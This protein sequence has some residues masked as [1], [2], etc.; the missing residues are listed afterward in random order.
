VGV[1]DEF[2]KQLRREVDAYAAW[3]PVTNSF[4]LGDYGLVSNGVFQ[5]LGNIT[6][7]GVDPGKGEPSG[8]AKIDFKSQGTTTVSLVGDA[9]VDALPDAPIDASLRIEFNDSDSCFAKAAKGWV[10]EIPNVREIAQKL[11]RANGWR[12]KYRVV[13]GVITGENCVIVTSTAKNASFELSGKADALSQIGLGAIGA[14]IR[15]ANENN[16]GLTIVGESGVVAL[17]MF[18][19]KLWGDQAR[20]LESGGEVDVEVDEAD[21]LEDDV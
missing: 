21:E 20:L 12:R 15:I 3:F 10:V 7:F 4:A 2:N 9:R 8:T 6:E 17:R 5:R 13:S 11:A 14:G 16:V 1:A 18:K 19:L